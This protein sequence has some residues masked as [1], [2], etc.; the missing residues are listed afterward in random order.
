M[1]RSRVRLRALVSSS[2]GRTPLQSTSAAQVSTM[3]RR[4]SRER[5]VRSSGRSQ[6]RV[7]SPKVLEGQAAI[8]TVA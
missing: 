5:S 7:V 4:S 3:Q 2:F 6:T 8:G 1:R